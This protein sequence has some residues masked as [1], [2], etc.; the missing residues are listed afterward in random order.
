MALAFGVLR[1][2]FVA[3]FISG[4]VLKG[5]IIGLALTIMVGQVPKLFGV[6]KGSD[7]FF[8][9]LGHLLSQLGQTQGW[10]LAVGAGS[11][12]VVLGFRFLAPRIV[13]SAAEPDRTPLRVNRRCTPRWRRSSPSCGSVATIRRAARDP[14][15]CGC[16]DGAPTPDSAHASTRQ[17]P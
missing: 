15:V 10:T 1:L 2:G 8:E 7:D 17:R 4:P 16:G 6:S 14:G 12:A 13:Y 5:F 3:S 11:L 9:Q